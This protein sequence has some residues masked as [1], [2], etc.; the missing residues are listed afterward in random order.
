[1]LGPILIVVSHLLHSIFRLLPSRLDSR[2]EVIGALA[3]RHL[4]RKS[5]LVGL[6]GAEV[7]SY[8]Y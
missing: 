7:V 8:M 1:M 4:S 3:E 2:G 5:S 6:R